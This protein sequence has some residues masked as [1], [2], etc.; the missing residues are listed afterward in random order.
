[1]NATVFGKTPGERLADELTLARE[2]VVNIAQV[3]VNDSQR[4]AIINGLALELENVQHM[5]R[6]T[7][8]VRELGEGS[9]LASPEPAESQE[10]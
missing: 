10:A 8:L 2:I 4:L 6:I 3:G 1:M 7:A 5:K 9:F